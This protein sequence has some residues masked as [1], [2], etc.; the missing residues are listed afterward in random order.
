MVLPKGTE[1]YES[2]EN[3]VKEA[4]SF[5]FGS[6]KSGQEDANSPVCSSRENQCCWDENWITFR[7]MCILHFAFYLKR[8]KGIEDMFSSNW[9]T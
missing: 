6:R 8:E 9:K 7:V 3:G 5:S 2:K 1:Q 4:P